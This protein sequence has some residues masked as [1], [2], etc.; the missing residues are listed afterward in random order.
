M[1][2]LLPAVIAA[3]TLLVTLA[4]I[5]GCV[6]KDLL[7]EE[8]GFTGWV[9]GD[10]A[11]GYGTIL[12]TLDDGFSWYR[13][14][15]I[16]QMPGVNF[17]AVSCISASEVFVA[18]DTMP[19][20]PGGKYSL[21]TLFYTSDGGISWNRLADTTLMQDVVFH[22]VNARGNGRIWAGGDHS[23]LLRSDNRGATWDL[24]TPDTLTGITFTSVA[25]RGGHRV[26]VTGNRYDSAGN[27][28]GSL[29]LRSYDGGTNWQLLPTGL[30]GPHHEIVA[31]NDT[32]LLMA[33]GNTV[34]RST[35]SAETW[36]PSYASGSLTV[37]SVTGDTLTYWA[38]ADSGRVAVM[39][40]G[41]WINLQPLSFIYSWRS[42]NS[43]GGTRAWATGNGNDPVRKGVVVYTRNKGQT[44]FLQQLPV[45]APL[46]ASSFVSG[47]K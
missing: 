42:I 30:P 41:T 47:M 38:S 39:S 20:G 44:W 21:G 7:P 35:D 15:T 27:H 14:G 34:V 5:H 36:F 28:T 33:T 32:I 13:Q 25:I 37:R 19:Y 16:S 10:Q 40:G 31:T 12:K 23:T 26:W 6:R 8:T 29:L 11:D 3:A 46:H 45:N 1:K 43:V 18:G 22:T 17:R 9:V 2:K 24:V 4:A